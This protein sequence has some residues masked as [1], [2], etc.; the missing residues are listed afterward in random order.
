M[1]KANETFNKNQLQLYF[2]QVKG[3]IVEI[4]LNEFYSN[5]TLKVGHHNSR[6]VNLVAK[7]QAFNNI[8]ENLK[9]GDRI[10]AKYYLSSHKKNDRYYTSATIL[11]AQKC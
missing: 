2:N 11:E 4:N 1:E 10:V 3:E 9:L 6:Q 8:I 7:T 5:L